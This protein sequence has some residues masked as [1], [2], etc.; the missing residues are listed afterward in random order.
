MSLTNRIL[1]PHLQFLG[2]QMNFIDIVPISAE[3]RYQRGY[4][5]Q[6]CS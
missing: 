2:E 3:K 1:L 4:H 6:H 5:R